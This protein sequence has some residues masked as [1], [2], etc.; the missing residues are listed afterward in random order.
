MHP[1]KLP[2]GYANHPIA[3]ESILKKIRL[4]AVN[5]IL[6]FSVIWRVWLNHKALR[7]ITSAGTE[8]SAMPIEIDFVR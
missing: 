3:P 4:G 2:P 1:V 8:S 6:L 7:K 5:E